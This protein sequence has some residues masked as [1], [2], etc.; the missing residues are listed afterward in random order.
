MWFQFNGTTGPAHPKFA[1]KA[2]GHASPTILQVPSAAG[3]ELNQQNQRYDHL[4]DQVC[5]SQRIHRYQKLIPSCCF[6]K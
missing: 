6:A 2:P 5:L 4:D 1:F 3:S